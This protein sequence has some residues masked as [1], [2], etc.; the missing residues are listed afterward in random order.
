MKRRYISIAVG[1]VIVTLITIFG[2]L[3]KINKVEVEFD[4]TPV[5]VDAVEI[6]DFST[7]K[8]GDSILSLNENVVK[9]RIMDSYEDNSVGVTDIVRVFPNKVIIYCEEH[10]P[11]CAIAKKGNADVYAV[12]DGD[13]QL[14]KVL[15]KAEVDLDELILIEGIEVVDTYNTPAFKE[16]N[17]FFKALEGAGL[18]YSEQAKFIKNINYTAGSL[19]VTTRDGYTDTLTYSNGTIAEVTHAFYQKYLAEANL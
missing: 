19:T 10:I 3:L 8:L 9:K 6:Y 17:G 18:D 2:N 12:A 1:I 16:I 14:D 5:S 7:I 15:S 13:F 11:M 4:K